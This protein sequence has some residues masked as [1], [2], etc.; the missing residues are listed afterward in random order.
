MLMLGCVWVAH[1]QAGVRVGGTRSSWS[2]C[3]WVAHAQAGVRADGTRSS[4]GACG[5]HTLRLGAAA[6]S[7]APTLIALLPLSSIPRKPHSSL[8]LS[9]PLS[10][11][12]A[13]P[14]A[15]SLPPTSFKIFGPILIVAA[16]VLVPVNYLGGGLQQQAQSD[17]DLTYSD[18]DMLSIANIP[19]QSSLCVQCTHCPL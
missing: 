14:P 3:V 18:I 2:A 16:A 15:P 12:Y 7:G 1:A 8:A 17:P 13:S 11:H 10:P 9:C 19:N 5:W 6:H 4:W